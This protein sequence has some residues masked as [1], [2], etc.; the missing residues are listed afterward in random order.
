[1]CLQEI[2]VE[3]D[4][5]PLL[6]VRGLGYHAAV[7]G[8]RAYNGVAILSKEPPQDVRRGLEDDVPDHEARVISAKVGDVRVISVYVPNGQAVGSE[9]YVYKLAWLERLRAYLDRTYNPSE[10]L[11]MGG[12]FN[13]APEWRDVAKPELWQETTLT[14]EEVRQAVRHV[15]DWGLQDT[16]RVYTQE[17][18]FYSWWDY[19]MLGFAKNNGLRIDQVYATEPMAARLKKAWIDRQERKGQKPSDHVPVVADFA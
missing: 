17:P 2:K 1:M 9:K 6:E 19:R 5:F 13:C 4:K 8:Q 12:D 16:F 14:S 7:Y 11:V 3:E 10:P 18:G 15:V